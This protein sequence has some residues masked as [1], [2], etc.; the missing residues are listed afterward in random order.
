MNYYSVNGPIPI[1]YLGEAIS[2]IE[3]QGWNVKHVCFSGMVEI[4]IKLTL[5]KLP[6]Q[7]SYAI[8]S[9]KESSEELKAP[10]LQLGGDSI[11]P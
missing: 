6:P 2:Q 11:A 10:T 9:T 8:V 5:Q 4:G 3:K 7:P 1:A